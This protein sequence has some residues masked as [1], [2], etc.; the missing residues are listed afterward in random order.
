[1]LFRSKKV[2]NS[3]L[4][5]LPFANLNKSWKEKLS[6]TFSYRRSINRPGM[7]Q[8]N[9]VIDFSDPYNLRFGNPDLVASTSDQLNLV[10]SRTK[11]SY[12]LNLSAG[13]HQV[14]GVFSQVRTLVESGKTEITWENISGRKEYELSTWNGFTILKKLK[15]NAS[16]S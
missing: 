11:K 2:S 15:V 1:M 12:F 7:N 16:A 10:L 14:E 9:P 3:Y 5:W 13:F 8:L 4:T 6:L